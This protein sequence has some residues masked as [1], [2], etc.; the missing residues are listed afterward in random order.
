MA[1]G[2]PVVTTGVSGIT[3]LVRNGE[4]GLIVEPDRPVELADALHRLIKDPELAFRLA[5]RGRITISERFD[6][7]TTAAQM[8]SLLTGGETAR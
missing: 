8:A 2:L 4:N 3:E 1:C 5:E 6:A 7:A